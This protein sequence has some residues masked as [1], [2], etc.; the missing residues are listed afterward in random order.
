MVSVLVGVVLVLMKFVYECAGCGVCVCVVFFF[1]FQ[2]EDGIRD[3]Q[4]SR[5]LGDV[6]KRQAKENDPLAGIVFRKAN[7]ALR[8]MGLEGRCCFANQRNTGGGSSFRCYGCG[9]HVLSM[10]VITVL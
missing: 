1:F 8:G 5:G 6:Y 7:R 9:C 2:A 10:V 3:A 4:E